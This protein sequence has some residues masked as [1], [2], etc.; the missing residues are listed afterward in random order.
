MRFLR[1]GHLGVL[2]EVGDLD[3][4]LRLATALRARPVPG[5]VDVV[6]AA[7]TVLLIH[8]GTTTCDRIA[9]QIG[10]LRL[11]PAPVTGGDPVEI[12]VA[13]DGADLASVAA[14]TGLTPAEVIERHQGAD[15]IVAF[16]GFAPG[17][18]YLVGGDPALRVARRD[19]PRTKVPAGSVALAGE[20]TGVYP[21]EGPGGW[22]LIGH[23]EA[24][25]WDLNREP[26]ALLP[27]GAR[28]RF[29]AARP[30]TSHDPGLIGPVPAG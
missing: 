1:A 21:R 22:Q 20:F 13:Y 30:P 26:P 3:T 14:A 15:Y 6:A 23:T 28:A 2:V 10:S 11:G 19:S 18:A 5:V 27:P 16:S 12:P 29:T 4:V 17:F 25:L 7:R 9:S 8:D 24:T